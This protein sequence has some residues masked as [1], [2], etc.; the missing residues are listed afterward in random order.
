MTSSVPLPATTTTPVHRFTVGDMTCEHCQGRVESAARS[1]AG[2]AEATVDLAAGTLTV[3]G[4]D[5]D[6][7]VRAVAE[8]GYPAAPADA[9]VSAT[10]CPLPLPMAAAA[11]QSAVPADAYTLRVDDMHCASCVGR[12]EAAI[13]AVAGVRAVAVNLV[14]GSAAV[15]GGEPGQVVQAVTEAGYGATFVDEPR[16]AGGEGYEIDILGMHCASCVQ[17]VETAL[18][19]VAGVTEAAVNL[20]EKKALVRGGS[21]EAAVQ[22]V[23]DQGYGA[24]LRQ[25]PPSDSFLIR[26]RPWPE[27]A[28]LEQ[29]GEILRAQ[30]PATGVA[31]E[32]QQLRVATS[33]HPADVLLRLTDLGY[34]AELAESFVD[35]GLQQAEATRL[36]IRRSWWRALWAGLVGF[37]IMA[38]HMGGL[39]PHP[40]ENRLFWAGAA[41]VCLLTMIYSGRNY[42]IGAWKQARHGAA[43]MDTLVAL[44]TGAAWL[45]SL[46][47]IVDPDFIPG[48]G[49]NLYLDAS[50]M[51]LAFLQLGHVLETRA[52]RTTS[53]AIGALVGLRARTAAVLRAAGQ[54][55]IPV[56][57]LRIGDRVRVKPGEKVPID[58][59]IVEG[60]TTIDESMLTGEPLAV[61]RDIGDPVTG[62]TMNRSGAFVLKVTRLGE[63]TTLARIIRMVK[64]A[65][66]SKPPIGRLADRIAGVFVPVV[67][68]VSL[69]S[70]AAWAGFATELR[71]AHGL[72]AAIAVLVIA[73]PCALGLATPIAIMVGT[74]RAAQ[75]NVLI[76]NSDALQTAATLTHVV[77]D[78]TGTLTEGRPAVT[79][80]FPAAGSSE[81]EVL[82]WAAS[83]ESGSEH[84]LAEAVLTAHLEH[85]GSLVRLDGFTAVPGRGVRAAHG[86]LTY[87]L[88]NHHFLVEEGLELPAGLRAEAER[89]AAR[90]GT[91]VWLGRG[92][93]VMGLLILKDPVRRDSAA[94]VKRLRDIGL[95]VV[96]CSGDARATAE[97]VAREVGIAEVHS[98]ILPEEKLEVIRGLQ[99]QGARVGMV[100]DGVNDAPALA[101]ADTGFAI[102]SGTDVAIEHADI[103]L[104]G[105]SLLLVADAIAISAA[106]IRTI[107][108]NLFGAFI[109]NVIGI[110]LAAGL[111][112]PFTGWLL[113]PMFASAAMALS[114]VT[115]VTNANRLRFFRP[116]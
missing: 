41:L 80:I 51:I 65:Q 26:L 72:T 96:M 61:A 92:T 79:G 87:L 1:V 77:V 82:R 98:E 63:D 4:G 36:E 64:T 57:L 37:A 94:A 13:R 60:R 105:D 56:S 69:I 34:Q 28:D 114:S 31:V 10:A 108:Q 25:R 48:A 116:R 88:G 3:R 58:G 73:C 97:A 39:F 100:G 66:M 47:V 107:K 12:V 103:T 9:G 71:W 113:Q 52:K 85:G 93:E 106:T 43:N 53:E 21:P 115:V 29:I 24:S 17:R 89:Q 15:E 99:R 45:S 55:E 6:A 68:T 49:N 23:L 38:G 86:D 111:F 104:T 8:A 42:F 30:D 70:F 22:A 50:V 19:A 67:I 20:I 54:A 5:S 27:T 112:Y 44:G 7:I 78:K 102:G 76:R 109:Y 90:G 33:Q 46:V 2:V 91:P 101:Q 81:Q 74:S 59:E 40:H 75:C 110:P 35:P 32:D 95:A 16:S 83:L 14:D 18:R 62:G 11:P 84:P